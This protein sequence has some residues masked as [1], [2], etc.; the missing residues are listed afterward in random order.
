[1]IRLEPG[2]DLLGRFSRELL[3]PDPVFSPET[4]PD[5]GGYTQEDLEAA[6]QA[7]TERI[8]D[9]YRSVVVFAEL[10]QRLGECEAPFE[11]LAAVHTLLGDELRHTALCARVAGWFGPSSR[12][13]V[14]LSGL[15]LPPSEDP[16]GVRALEIIVRELVVAEAES[17]VSFLAYRDATRDPLVKG[18]LGMLLRDEVRHA[19]AGERLQAALEDHLG[20]LL[21]DSERERLERTVAEDRAYLRDRYDQGAQGGPGRA[22]GACITRED[23]DAARRSLQRDRATGVKPSLAP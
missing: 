9:E 1:M 19:A 23:L 5:L 13:T 10:L 7:W 21:P 16:P 14:D 2:T 17:V 6:H 8:V 18:A 15:A 12:F 3:G 4:R 22:L 11:T 20:D